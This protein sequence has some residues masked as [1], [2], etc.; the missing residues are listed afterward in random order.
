MRPEDPKTLE[1]AERQ[2]LANR[3]AARLL[4]DGRK[5][6]AHDKLYR[7]HFIAHIRQLRACIAAFKAKGDR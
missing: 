1:Q 5:S 4:P 3:K 2:L 7:A 6:F